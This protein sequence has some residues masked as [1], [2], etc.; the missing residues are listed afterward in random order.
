MLSFAV[1]YRIM[2]DN[3]SSLVVVA[4]VRRR[5]DCPPSRKQCYDICRTFAAE[6]GIA[7]IPRLILWSFFIFMNK[8]VAT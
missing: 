4:R 2:R 3:N 6:R 1:K 8:G 7:A 5:G